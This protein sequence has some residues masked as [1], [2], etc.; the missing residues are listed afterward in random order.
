[1]HKNETPTPVILAFAWAV[2]ETCKASGQTWEQYLDPESDKRLRLLACYVTGELENSSASVS[3]TFNGRRLVLGPIGT[4]QKPGISAFKNTDGNNGYA[5]RTRCSVKKAARI[6][7]DQLPQQTRK[8][9][10][11]V[12]IWN[13]A[14]AV[15]KTTFETK[16]AE[17]AYYANV[18]QR[19]KLLKQFPELFH[20]I[21]KNVE[22]C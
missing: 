3:V 18:G 20:R 6:M 2:L 21:L 13:Y 10:D 14:A 8:E 12:T 9:A 7:L 19:R 11:P 1:M 5:Y 16:L 17:L 15:T 4:E 22:P